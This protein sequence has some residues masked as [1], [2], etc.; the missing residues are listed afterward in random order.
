[1]K[2]ENIYQV[3]IMIAVVACYF[4]LCAV[5]FSYILLRGR[6]RN[7]KIC[8]EIAVFVCLFFT[9]S[10]CLAIYFTNTFAEIQMFLDDMSKDKYCEKDSTA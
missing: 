1:M 8:F 5:V 4:W 3:L 7:K 2:I 6:S 10:I 9:W